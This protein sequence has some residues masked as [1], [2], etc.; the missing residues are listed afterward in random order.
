MRIAGDETGIAE[1]CATGANS[2][3]VMDSAADENIGAAASAPA[4][5]AV[6]AAFV[7]TGAPEGATFASAGTTM[8]AAVAP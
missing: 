2:G 7:P 5:A 4:G 3:A 1:P 6:V 8:G